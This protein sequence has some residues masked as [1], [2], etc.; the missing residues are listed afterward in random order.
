MLFVLWVCVSKRRDWIQEV[1]W[2]L[3]LPKD[4]WVQLAFCTQLSGRQLVGQAR[5]VLVFSEQV[6]RRGLQM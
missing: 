5:C 4:G 1:H 6:Q 3:K 2:T